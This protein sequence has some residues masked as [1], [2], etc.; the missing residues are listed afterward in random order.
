MVV[1][2]DASIKRFYNRLRPEEALKRD[3]DR[4]VDLSPASQDLLEPL[5]KRIEMEAED[6]TCQLVTG[7]IGTGKSTELLRLADQLGE[8]AF[9]V[10]YSDAEALRQD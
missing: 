1:D 3:D 6:F 9:A 8:A 5:R 4:W 7:F 2:I 10:V